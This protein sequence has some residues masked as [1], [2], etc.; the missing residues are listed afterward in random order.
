VLATADALAGVDLTEL[1]AL[2]R[3]AGELTAKGVTRPVDLFA[4]TP[5]G[6]S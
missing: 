1:G 3:P 2:P 6:G 4:L 5:T